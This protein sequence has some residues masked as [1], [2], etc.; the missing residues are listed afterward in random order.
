MNY[1][2]EYAPLMKRLIALFP[3]RPISPETVA[4]YWEM[5]SDLDA[6]L[7]AQAVK[8]CA[9]TCEWFPTV[10]QLREAYEDIVMASIAD[11]MEAMKLFPHRIKNNALRAAL[12]MNVEDIYAKYRDLPS[13]TNGMYGPPPRPRR[14]NG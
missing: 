9:A 2:A 7:F 6:D 1:Q 3:Q 12:T 4:A 5:I 10:K 13:E 8:H 11:P 14:L